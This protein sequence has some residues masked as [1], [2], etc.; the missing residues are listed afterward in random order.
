MTIIE[1]IGW[2]LV[3]FIVLTVVLDATMFRRWFAW[4]RLLKQIS[5]VTIAMVIFACVV[6]VVA[7]LV[8]ITP[9]YAEYLA[10]A[11][12]PASY[13]LLVGENAAGA[14]LGFVLVP[15]MLL[16]GA[17]VVVNRIGD[18]VIPPLDKERQLRVEQTVWLN[19]K[20]PKRFQ[21]KTSS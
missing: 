11:K 5:R 2:M 12:L 21:I 8:S 6:M 17:L 7:M 10:E 16:F 20:L 13:A 14:M 4:H 15:I 3:G 19:S 18:W 1:I 9:I